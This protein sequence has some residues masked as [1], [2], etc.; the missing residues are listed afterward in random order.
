MKRWELFRELRRHRKQAN[1]RAFN[2]E[3]NKVAKYLVGFVYALTLIYLIFFAIIFS[4]AANDSRFMTT[5]EFIMAMAPFILLIDFLLRFTA[6]QTPT[7]LIKPYILLPISKYTCIDTLILSSLFN[8]GNLTWFVMFIPYALMSI[9]FT[10]G[11]WVTLG[12]FLCY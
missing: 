8:W 12:V 5:V 1:K 11:I 3:Q 10:H 7:Q 2:F 4:L 6:Q 9:V